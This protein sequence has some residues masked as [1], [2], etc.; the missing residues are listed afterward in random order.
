MLAR[1]L[2]P[3]PAAPL[4]PNGGPSLADFWHGERCTQRDASVG[5]PLKVMHDGR[6]QTR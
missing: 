1:R 4:P 3:L 2:P 5:H 6:G